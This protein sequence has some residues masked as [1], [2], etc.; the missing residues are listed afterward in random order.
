MAVEPDPLTP[1]QR[2]ES[3]PEPEPVAV[4]LAFV[5]GL[6]LIAAAICWQALS[7]PTFGFDGAVGPGFFPI[8]ISLAVLAG[9]VVH[10]VML[11]RK[12]VRQPR[13]AGPKTQPVFDARQLTVIGILAVS[14]VIGDFI[15]L[16]AV[17]GLIL[18][19]GLLSVERLKPV[20]T[21]AFTI[22]TLLVLYLIFDA[23]LGM[24]IGLNGLI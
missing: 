14:V 16:F 19:V 23:W 18:V 8:P 20:E 13:K 7:L 11:A 15:G 2:A 24:N 6:A 5:V 3:A 10:A 12:L 9:L 22:G 21:A 17:M 4:E 1:P